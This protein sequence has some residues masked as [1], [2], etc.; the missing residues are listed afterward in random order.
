MDS[1]LSRTWMI[2]V[3]RMICLEGVTQFSIHKHMA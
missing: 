2:E 3:Y 1:G